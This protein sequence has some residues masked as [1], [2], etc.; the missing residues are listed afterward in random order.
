MD[1]ENR[2]T[3][4]KRAA[5][6]RADQRRL[7]HS[8]GD[9]QAACR[10]SEGETLA[11]SQDPDN[12]NHE[13]ETIGMYLRAEGR[14]RSAMEREAITR[15]AMT[16]FEVTTIYAACV[17]IATI[18]DVLRAGP[19]PDHAETAAMRTFDDALRSARGVVE[20]QS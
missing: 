6:R 14:D 10:R 11:L 13:V 2:S 12:V 17:D 20:A 18:L 7:R 4:D 5:R 19:A 1:S 8:L 9:R 3:I 15:L 16:P